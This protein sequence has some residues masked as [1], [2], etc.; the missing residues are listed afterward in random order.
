MV[1]FGINAAAS[2]RLGR[3]QR[4]SLGQDLDY[5]HYYRQKAE[6]FIYVVR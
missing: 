1:I 6:V 4:A 3:F 5:N 2:R